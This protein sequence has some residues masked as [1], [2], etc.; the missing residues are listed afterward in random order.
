M[1]RREFLK[2]MTGVAGYFALSDIFH[3]NS[4]EAANTNGYHIVL[5]A[6]L[7]LPWRSKKF[8]KTIEGEN[9]F[10]QKK[11]MIDNINSWKD[12]REVA[13]LGD[14]PARYGNEEEFLAV[15]KVLNEIS[16]PKYIVIGN[17][18][19]AYRDKPS[20]KGKLK[21]GTYEER[22]KKLNAFKERYKMPNFYYSRAVGNYR[23][24]YLAPDTCSNLNV[25]LSQKQLEWIRQE[26]LNHK[27]GPII[28]FCHAPLTNTLKNYS[29]FVNKPQSVA[30]PEN[31]LKEIL[32]YAPKG[33]LWVSGHT[34]TP[35][36]NESYADDAVNRY[37]DNLVNI[38]NP[39][40]DAKHLYTNSLFLYDDRAVVKTFDHKSN[41]W[42]EKF[43][44]EYF[45]EF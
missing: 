15:D 20:K 36:E 10:A 1:K 37:N 22:V 2:L 42:V 18:D 31:A 43:T 38:H 39:T 21:R 3:N 9:I 27:N 5:I 29:S 4:I 33:S 26:I 8:P 34:H 25:E 16:L 12:A 30:N 17:H 32:K 44:R 28:F 6:D 35:P 11:K 24:L 40:I 7:H 23:L 41:M 45:S 13:L 19:Y 14:F